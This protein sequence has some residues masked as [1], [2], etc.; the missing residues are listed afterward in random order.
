MAFPTIGAGSCAKSSVVGTLI[1]RL[2]ELYMLGGG[3]GA[4]R[5]AGSR[6]ESEACALAEQWMAEAGLAVTRDPFGNVIGRLRGLRRELPEVWAGSHLDSVPDGGKYDGALGVVAA[7]E[8]VAAVGS[9]R[10][11]SAS[12]P[13]ATRSAAA[14]EASHW[15]NQAHCPDATSS[16]TSSRGRCLNARALRSAS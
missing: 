11:R 9:I 1:E 4:N 14:T 15:R 2:E 16:C 10:A 8:A 5:P 12:S 6:A 13:F 7:I 3:R